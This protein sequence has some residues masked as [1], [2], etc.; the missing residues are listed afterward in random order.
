MIDKVMAL[1]RERIRRRV[2]RLRGAE[3]HA[4]EQALRLWLGLGE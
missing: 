2:G 1:R 3:M 4:I